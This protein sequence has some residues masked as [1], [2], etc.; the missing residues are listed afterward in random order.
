[1]VHL[2]VSLIQVP[3][4]VIACQNFMQHPPRYNFVLLAMVLVLHAQEVQYQVVLLVILHNRE[5]LMEQISVCATMDFI[6]MLRL[7]ANHVILLV[8]LAQI[9]LLVL[10]ALTPLKLL[11]Q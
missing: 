6:L 11:I 1:M 9:L 2:N 10:L 3:Y 8:L 4:H 5:H 7:Y